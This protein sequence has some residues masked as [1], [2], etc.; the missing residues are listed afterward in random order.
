MEKSVLQG[1]NSSVFST[2]KSAIEKGTIKNYA[3]LSSMPEFNENAKQ[4]AERLNFLIEGREN[5]RKSVEQCAQKYKVIFYANLNTLLDENNIKGDEASSL[6]KKL[7]QKYLNK[8]EK[9]GYF[10]SCDLKQDLSQY[11]FEKLFFF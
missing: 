11:M 8:I 7:E 10:L 6:K 4:I 2:T 3:V 9:D 5:Y 1:Q